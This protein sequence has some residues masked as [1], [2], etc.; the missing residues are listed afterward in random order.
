MDGLYSCPLL[1]SIHAL[2]GTFFESWGAVN[3][4]QVPLREGT[5]EA[6]AGNRKKPSARGSLARPRTSV[7]AM[8][9]W[10][11]EQ[12][13]NPESGEDSQRK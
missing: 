2:S 1:E 11:S 7:R 12:P 3:P 13:W 10:V 8:M 5:L 9:G 6:P 4:L